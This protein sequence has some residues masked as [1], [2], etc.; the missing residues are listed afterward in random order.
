MSDIKFNT[1]ESLAK[2]SDKPILF[3]VSL[4]IISDLL[5]CYCLYFT[6]DDINFRYIQTKSGHRKLYRTLD[7]AYVDVKNI[8]RDGVML[9]TSEHDQLDHDNWADD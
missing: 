5:D 8:D 6:Y 1:V 7:L 9:C 4:H 3:H 2:R